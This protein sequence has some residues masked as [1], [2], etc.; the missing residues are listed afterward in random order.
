MS[1]PSGSADALDG[2]AAARARFTIPAKHFQ[3]V[4]EQPRRSLAIPI[5]PDG[6]PLEGDR[7]A[8]DLV[9]GRPKPFQAA[10][11]QVGDLRPGVD[12]RLEEDL[13]SVDVPD[14]GDNLL[15][16]EQALYPAAATFKSIKE[17][18]KVKLERFGTQITNLMYPVHFAGP[19]P[20]NKTEFPN[21]PVA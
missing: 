2:C 9:N 16:K 18:R 12:A 15:I 14:T 10:K 21:V 7:L 20:Q 3:T 5:I 19:R 8:Q 17:R 4:L 1:A 6:R 11:P 13:I